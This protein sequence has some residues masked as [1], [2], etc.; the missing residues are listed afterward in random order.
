MFENRSIIWACIL[1][2]NIICNVSDKWITLGLWFHLAWGL[3][4]RVGERKPG[5]KCEGTA[6]DRKLQGSYWVPGEEIQA[7]DDSWANIRGSVCQL[8]DPPTWNICDTYT[9]SCSRHWNW[10]YLENSFD[11]PFCPQGSRSRFSVLYLIALR[12]LWEQNLAN[13]AQSLQS[14]ELWMLE[15]T[16]EQLGGALFPKKW[17]HLI[18]HLLQW[19]HPLWFQI[20]RWYKIIFE[21]L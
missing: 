17:R 9:S 7:E 4:P 3:V 6:D 15:F 12:F 19:Q 2:K 18:F 11:C 14:T 1:L 5:W 16:I 10:G 20:K 8:I 13:W 21:L